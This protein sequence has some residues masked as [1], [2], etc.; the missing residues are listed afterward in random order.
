MHRDTQRRRRPFLVVATLLSAGLL[1]GAC[2]EDDAPDS[3]GVT[4]TVA[5][6]DQAATPSGS[7][8]TETPTNETPVP[9]ITPPET[10]EREG[11][12]FIAPEGWVGA[13]EV[14]TSPDGEVTL[15]FAVIEWEAGMESEALTLP[16][17][18]VNIDRTEIETPIGPGA[19]H[20]IELT[21][22]E[23]F[24]RHA[25]VRVDDVILDWWLAA[26]S[27]E[28]LDAQQAALD[29]VLASVIE[30]DE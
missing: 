29:Q 12:S 8:A 21:D 15:L 30:V 22:S 20:T 1:L 25:M 5:A 23:V 17:G 18:A 26:D 13:S 3:P 7:G 27:I 24:E 10:V 28:A 11:I 16:E 19:V 2:A 9:T 6:T 4:A 14:W